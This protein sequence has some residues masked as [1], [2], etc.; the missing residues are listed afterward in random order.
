MNQTGNHPGDY[1]RPW[2]IRSLQADRVWSDFQI[3]G[4][5][6]LNVVAD[7]NFAISPN[8]A[9]SIYR[10]PT[11][12]PDNQ[13]DDDGN[14]YIDDCHGYNFTDLSNRITVTRSPR[15]TFSRTLHGAI[16][17]AIICGNGTQESPYEFG[18]APEAKWAGVI[19]GSVPLGK[20]G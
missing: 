8:L 16:C 12:I 7:G 19:G 5:G 13:I 1:K 2:Y 3:Q 6:T 18:I 11:E 15:S 9:V 4:D 17:A 10:N 20:R 14:G